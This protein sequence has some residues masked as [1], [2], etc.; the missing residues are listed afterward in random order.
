MN[1]R[2][3]GLLL[4]LLAT[5][6]AAGPIA[7]R[8]VPEPLRPWIPWVLHG[9]AAQFCPPAHNNAAQRLCNWPSA[10]SL[11]LDT[12]G[13]RFELRT[14]LDAPGWT[15]LPGD[16]PRWPQE[17]T[18]DGRAAAVLESNGF[19]ALWL[20]RGEHRVKGR[21]T[22]SV[23]PESLR[24]PP[25]SGLVELNLSGRDVAHPQR[26]EQH[27]LWLGRRA[28]V[29][30]EQP[31]RLSLRVFRLIDDSIPLQVTTRIEIDAGGV[32]REEIIGPALLA[33]LVPLSL[34]GD[35]PA[36]LEDDGRLRVQV[37]PGSWS[38]TLVARSKAPV[39]AL[40]A[41]AKHEQWA[42]QEIWSLQA[43]PELRVIEPEGLPAIDP[44]QSG[45][46]GEWHSLP[47][48]LVDA[49][50]RLTLK[51]I[52]RGNPELPPDQ[53]QLT[54]QLWLDFDGGGFTVQ[55]QLQG[56]LSRNSRLETQAPITLGQVQ[57]DGQPQLI[58]QHGQGTGVE[59]RNTALNLSA[60][61]RIDNGVR[62][63]PASGWNA[64]VQGIE[65][66]L[67]LPPAWRLLA[68][69]GVDNVPDTWLSRWSLLDLFLVLVTT[70]AALRL[71]G[72]GTAALALITLGLTWHEP[73]APQWTWL[74]LVAAIALLRALPTN[75]DGS[76]RLRKLLVGYQWIA[77]GVLAYVALPFAIQQARVSL[78]PQ[79][80]N[81][82][83]YQGFSSGSATA[84]MV[85]AAPEAMEMNMDQASVIR[86]EESEAGMPASAE[87][88]RLAKYKLSAIDEQVRYSSVSQQSIQKLDPNVL[89][90]TGPGLP[91]WTWRQAR[92][93]W[94]GPVTAEQN[95]RLWLM[96]PVLTR[97][98]GWV[99]IVL[100]ALL[101]A[102][103][104]QLAPRLRGI[105]SGLRTASLL[106]S[107]F[108]LA[109]LMF[110][111]SPALAQ[112][113]SPP[114]SQILEELRA[115]LTAPPDCLPNCASWSRMDLNIE[116][117]RLLLRLTAEA[118]IEV[119]L[120]LPVP[121][122]SGGQSRVWQPQQVLLDSEAAA[123]VRE[124]GGAL[125]LRVPAGRHT[126]LLSGDLTGFSQLQLPLIPAPKQVH[127]NAPGWLVSGVDAQGSAGS[128]LDLVREQK[129]AAASATGEG[130]QESS[131]QAFTPLLRV[132]RRLQLG[133]VWRVESTLQ[134]VGSADGAL[135]A[136]LAALPG[137]VVTGDSVRRVGTQIQASFAPGQ[138]QIGW[139]S[140]LETQASLKLKAS[141]SPDLIEIWHFDVSPLWR[142]EFDG[143]PPL[144]ESPE[145]WPPSS[146]QPWPGE[147]LN[148]SVARPTAVKGQILTLDRA[149]L[150]VRPGKR[151]TDY[152]LSLVLRASQGGQHAL[153][154][155]ANLELQG[156]E[157]DGQTQPAR[158]EGERVILPLHPGAQTIQ[159]RLRADEGIGAFTNTPAL[160]TGLPGVN[161]RVSVQ[162][163]E[164]RW[165]LLV[166]GPALGPA[167]LFWGVLAVLLLVAAALGRSGFT[168][169]KTVQ[170]ALLMIGLSQLPL[171]GAALVAG[172]LF[173]LSLRGR[174]PE[175]WSANRFNFVQVLLAL[176]TLAALSTLFGAV[177]QGLL[178]TP[179]MQIAG[180]GSSAF[181]LQWY[182]DRFATNLPSA[183]VI[184]VS[185]W[186]YRGL[187]LLWALWLANSLLNWLRW[188]W[189]QYASNGLWKKKPVVVMQAANP[190]IADIQ[191]GTTSGENP[192]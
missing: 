192:S 159:L 113:P 157:I 154:L 22:W 189:A 23:L 27:Q 50:A 43:H 133:Q 114:N 35:L 112:E 70:I 81:E 123:L 8:D 52:Q 71:F 151:A 181:Q 105:T 41:D 76:G 185:I 48:F 93:S 63:I 98:L 34:Y 125:W 40:A 18:V 32:V 129:E 26:D 45:V 87:P 184:S 17:V 147:S 12:D 16:G 10:V 101:A 165:V 38:L 66:T 79:L 90:Q 174:M 169:L 166:G 19:P 172:W 21:Y 5:P 171:Y 143:L 85:A 141:D 120:P 110:A 44:R 130:T 182:Q 188:G 191:S 73:G 72:R 111:P 42:A 51:E 173:A 7:E 47:A 74:N 183:W 54:R 134:R 128:A 108:A 28:V 121:R 20:E 37:R 6:A 80:E 180:N 164:D 68:A 58:T 186:F 97:L 33:G 59:V 144:R 142:V 88:P 150:D 9:Q 67:H 100:I 83:A 131:G 117:Q 13:G 145:A 62:R 55:D 146:F 61:S 187:M 177:A 3:A 156:L 46:P 25:E 84:P 176:W 119:A 126:V 179:D 115:R 118:Q 153:P 116:N 69:P 99:S 82:F 64:D 65:T 160:Q 161:A 106:L 29:V 31:E 148:V 49:G 36:R 2:L 158:R 137:E 91:D 190:V 140:S 39:A 127:I 92:L 75:F 96:P 163:P 53:L 107:A 178:G 77:A 155:P 1:V 167:V 103:C 15:A 86:A 60:D 132:T 175:S 168:P 95:F 56:A 94:S 11:D 30:D 102:R 57:I 78:Y 135:V 139:T 4:L 136:T 170:W 89:T 149:D 138:G 162:L 104:L 124:G 24:V 14:R 109:S 122:L 152:T